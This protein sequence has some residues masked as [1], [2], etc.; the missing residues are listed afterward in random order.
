M[1]T[2]PHSR[3]EVSQARYLLTHA[4]DFVANEDWQGLQST[5][6]MILR[7]DH[8]YRLRPRTTLTLVHSHEPGDA[9]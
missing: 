4:A 3:E 5:A 8:T 7:A 9:A 2:A 1:P 6:W